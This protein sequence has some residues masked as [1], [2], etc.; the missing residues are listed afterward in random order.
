[1]AWLAVDKDE[2]EL[3]FELEPFRINN[4]EWMQGCN[5]VKLPTDSIEKLIGK[6]LTWLDEP[7]EC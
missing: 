6:K 7:V 4:T 5:Y 1:M 3:I 2:T